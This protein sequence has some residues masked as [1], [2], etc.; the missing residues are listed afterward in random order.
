MSVKAYVPPRLELQILYAREFKSLKDIGLLYGVS[1][2][3]TMKW[4]R[5]YEIPRRPRHAVLPL[6][7]I[8]GVLHKKCRGRTHK[9]G[10]WLP[11]TE[12]WMVKSGKGKGN[13]RSQCKDCEYALKGA[14]QSIPYLKIRFAIEELV[15]RLGKMETCRRIGISQPHLRNLLRG[16]L[17]RVQYATAQNALKA[18]AIARNNN[19]K[20]H[21][22]SIKHGASQRGRIERIPNEQ[23]DFYR[24][25][26]NGA[27]KAKKLD[28]TR[29]S[30]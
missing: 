26:A 18:L 24:R 13:P 22:K 2:T 29:D 3:T 19:E 25:T 15:H 5:D 7:R 23:N 11:I 28:L 14:R 20:R 30:E 16:K 27:I 10:A 9:D 21:R 1:S 17:D 4:L 12:F 8:D 6:R